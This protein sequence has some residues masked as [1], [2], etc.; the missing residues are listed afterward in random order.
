MN[1]FTNPLNSELTFTMYDFYLDTGE[2]EH[3]KN[4][5]Y[6][7]KLFLEGKLD[8][9]REII[10]Y[11]G[12]S[13]YRF[14]KKL[15][16]TYHSDNKK[17]SIIEDELNKIEFFDTDAS[18]STTTSTTDSSKDK[19]KKTKP[20]DW[21]NSI[22]NVL[23]GASQLITSLKDDDEKNEIKEKE[24]EKDKKWKYKDEDKDK[25]DEEDNKKK[26]MFLIIGIP[27][28]LSLLSIITFI[29]LKSNK[30]N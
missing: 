5:N 17:R 2:S 20:I 30:K 26:K 13:F 7:N 4:Y 29:V 8:K 11:Y 21:I 12:D 16:E 23:S 9:I 18:A 19:A 25:E 1:T 3:L 10:N 22:G 27:V 28:F 6:L 14:S 24:K 15:Y